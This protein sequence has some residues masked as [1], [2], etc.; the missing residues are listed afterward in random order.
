MHLMVVLFETL[1]MSYRVS[2]RLLHNQSHMEIVGC[3]ESLLY[4][5]QCNSKQIY[6][7][8]EKGEVVSFSLS[9]QKGGKVLRVTFYRP[10]GQLS[11]LAVNAD[12]SSCHSPDT[13]IGILYNFQKSAPAAVH[14]FKP[15]AAKVQ[16]SLHSKMGKNF[17]SKSN[18]AIQMKV[19]RDQLTVCHGD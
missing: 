7:Q 14:F 1:N 3:I 6:A 2:L 8:R 10:R 13:S 9:W 11:H 4:S 19:R 5:I 18:Q 16:V 12:G 17:F 15:F